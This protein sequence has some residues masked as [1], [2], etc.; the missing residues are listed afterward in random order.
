VTTRQIYRDVPLDIAG[1]P[2]SSRAVIVIQ[3]A[4][5]V[6]DHIREV[7]GRFAD[8]G[9]YAL[10]PELFHRVGSPEVDY[11]NFPEAMTAMA[12]L[13]ADGIGFDLAAAAGFLGDA[14][15]HQSSIAIVGYCMGGTVA[16]YGATLGIV[17][18]AATFYGGG[19][20]AGRFGFAPLL[21]L[22]PRLQCDWIGL[23]GDLDKGIPVEQ[24]EALRTAA[25][26]SDHVTEIVRY[27]DAEHGFH[28]DARPAV[29]NPDAAADAHAQTLA[30]F[31]AHLRDR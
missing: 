18:A 1:S 9:Y 2:E 13:D 3:E 8:A 25:A 21:E 11:D 12:S 26:T 10:A 20:E 28:C 27:G 6:N 31:C 14:G 30:F 17:G 5:G 22:A 23:Y 19:I 16:F 15:F 7:V 4:F 29:F 24:V